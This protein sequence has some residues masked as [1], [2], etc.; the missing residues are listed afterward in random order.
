MTPAEQQAI[1]RLTADLDRDS[2]DVPLTC[3]VVS[4]DDLR[5]LLSLLRPVAS[6]EGEIVAIGLTHAS[7][8][9]GGSH[10][11]CH[12]I[13]LSVLPGATVGQRVRVAVHAVGEEARRG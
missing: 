10:S 11:V 12:S 4:R 5:T 2:Y 9:V 13:H 7:V 6:V 3:T 1:D 8:W